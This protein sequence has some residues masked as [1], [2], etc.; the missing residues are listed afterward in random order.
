MCLGAYVEFIPNVNV[1]TIFLN[2]CNLRDKILEEV[3][4]GWR[5]LYVIP[6]IP[7]SNQSYY[8]STFPTGNTLVDLSTGQLTH[9]PINLTP[10]STILSYEVCLFRPEGLTECPR[11]TYPY[12]DPDRLDREI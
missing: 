3:K 2:H 10:M 9:Q 8:L 11:C 12:S 5:V 4:T 7:A 6:P 1:K